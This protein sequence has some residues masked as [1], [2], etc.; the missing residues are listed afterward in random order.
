MPN[1]RSSERRFGFY[2]VIVLGLAI[3]GGAAVLA[4]KGLPGLQNTPTA[5]VD[6]KSVIGKTAN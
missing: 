6:G 4:T 5:V 3:V 1:S 2:A